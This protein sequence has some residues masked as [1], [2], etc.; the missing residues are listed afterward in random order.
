M[1]NKQRVDFTCMKVLIASLFRGRKVTGLMKDSRTAEG[2]LG[3][4][5]LFLSERKDILFLGYVKNIKRSI[6]I[7]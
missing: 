7:V 1:I 6:S 4:V 5:R 2:T 3:Y